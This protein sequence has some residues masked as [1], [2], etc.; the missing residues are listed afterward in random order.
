VAQ[1]LA[2][3]AQAG[4]GAVAGGRA[5]RV[6]QPPAGVGHLDAEL[7]AVAAR[8]HLDPQRTAAGLQTVLDRVLDQR[9]D[10][11]A[12]QGRRRGRRIDVDD[13]IEVVLEA[14][15]LDVE[16][17]ADGGDLVAQAEVVLVRRPQRVAKQLR[18]LGDHA[19]RRGGVLV[20]EGAQRV[21]RVE[22][23]VRVD[24]VAQH[25]QLGLGG[26]RGGAQRALGLDVGTVAVGEAE[27]EGAPRHQHE[28]RIQR[29]A[30]HFRLEDRPR[31]HQANRDLPHHAG[32]QR[33]EKGDPAQ[34]RQAQARQEAAVEQVQ[35]QRAAA[36]QGRL[37]QLVLEHDHLGHQPGIGHARHRAQVVGERV[38]RPPDE[39]G[40][41]EAG[42]G[43]GPR[44]ARR[45]ERIMSRS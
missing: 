29:R 4:A 27:V 44:I 34:R 16:V 12:G 23:E 22:Q 3:V 39:L 35:Q 18:Q 1:P 45:V 13:D 37:A 2:Q 25:G 7:V 30:R 31:V 33:R 28:D 17:V 40:R 19:A 36:Q 21:E 26:Q 5:R 42:A 8:P 14:D 10:E 6:G 24:L 32:G 38:E 9:V 43:H 15:L 41:P 11:K 20:D